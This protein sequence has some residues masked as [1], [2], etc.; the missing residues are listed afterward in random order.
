[1]KPL[2]AILIFVLVGLAACESDKYRRAAD[3]EVFE[4]LNQRSKQVLGSNASTNLVSSLTGNNPESV[5]PSEIIKERFA[6][7]GRTINLPQALE[8]A[9][10]NNRAYQLQRE[11]LYLSALSLT[12]VR[13]QFSWITGFPRRPTG[14][15]RKTMS[16]S[17]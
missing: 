5:T 8:M 3:K 14:L 2:N 7:S 6:D 10:K 1:M 11:T 12:G 17:T 16:L 15:R 9:E 13:H 4:I